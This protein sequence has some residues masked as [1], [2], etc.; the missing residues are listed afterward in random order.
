VGVLGAW[1]IGGVF[2]AST[3]VP[4]TPGFGGDALGV[5]STDPNIDV[6]NLIADQ[7]AVCQ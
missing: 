1:Q 2:E 4:F 5:N 7:V 3:D 6:P